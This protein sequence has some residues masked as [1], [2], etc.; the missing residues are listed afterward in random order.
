[1]CAKRTKLVII[2]F[3]ILCL[4]LLSACSGTDFGS[5]ISKGINQV[6]EGIFS[7][8]SGIGDSL[9]DMFKGFGGFF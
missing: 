1:M 5:G 8:L 3:V 9:R 4:S 6:I 2:I 7:G